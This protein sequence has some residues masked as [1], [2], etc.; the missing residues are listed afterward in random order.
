MYG[1]EPKLRDVTLQSLAKG[2][3]AIIEDTSKTL[4][5]GLRTNISKTAF[6]ILQKN[7]SKVVLASDE[8][9]RK[10]MRLIYERL[11]IVVCPSGALPIAAILENPEEFKGKRGNIFSLPLKKKK[12]G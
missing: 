7:L 6:Q 1:A 3:V 2:E 9:I 12:K 10:A 8:G 5:D 11:K 4:A